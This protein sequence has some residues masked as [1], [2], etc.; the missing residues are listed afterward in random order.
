[1]NG[2]YSRRDDPTC[3]HE[4]TEYGAAWFTGTPRHLCL[5]CGLVTLPDDEDYG[6]NYDYVGGGQ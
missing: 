5:D 3:P 6:E 1:M 2:L 4:R